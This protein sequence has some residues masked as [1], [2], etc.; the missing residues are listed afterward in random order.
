MND[1]KI[2]EKGKVHKSCM[3]SEPEVEVLEYDGGDNSYLVQGEG[4]K[5]WINT[6]K[7]IKL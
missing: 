4:F 5:I 7:L 1:F 3:P 6:D 2:G